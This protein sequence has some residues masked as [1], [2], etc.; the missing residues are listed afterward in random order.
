MPYVKGP[1]D[2]SA[3]VSFNEEMTVTLHSCVAGAEEYEG[4]QQ[5][6]YVGNQT[7]YT[8]EEQSPDGVDYSDNHLESTSGGGTEVTYTWNWTLTGSE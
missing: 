4:T 7:L 8:G 6:A 3:E 1:H 2:Y 5:P